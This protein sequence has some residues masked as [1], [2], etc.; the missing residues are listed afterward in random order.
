MGVGFNSSGQLGVVGTASSSV[1][2]PIPGLTAI[3][4]VVAGR[5]YSLALKPDGTVWAWGSNSSGIFGAATPDSSTSPVELPGLSGIT[6]ITAGA[7][8]ALALSADGHV[9]AWGDNTYGQLGNGTTS[10]NSTLTPTEVRLESVTS[11]ATGA[12]HNLAIGSDGSVWASGNDSNGQL[13]DGLTGRVDPT[14]AKVATIEHT[15]EIAAGSD[16]SLV[17]TADGTLYAFGAD[18]NGQLGDGGNSDQSSPEIVSGITDA[19][20]SIAAGASHSVVLTVGSIDSFGLNTSGQLGDD[21]TADSSVPVPVVS[22]PNNW[23]RPS[24]ATPLVVTAG[25]DST[26]ALY[27]DGSITSFGSNANGQLGDANH[28]DMNF[29]AVVPWRATPER[30]RS[31]PITRLRS[32]RTARYGLLAGMHSANWVTV[33]QWIRQCPSKS[34]AFLESLQLRP[35]TDTHLR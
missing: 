14:A 13:G 17:L 5:G 12:T 22:A 33:R 26:A 32:N 18:G 1:P 25:G 6:A 11:I 16:H 28:V 29:P 30:F 9:Y 2:V 35:V 15:V 23:N 27:S 24:Q 10:P 31:V 21:S 19:I 8:D 3:S 20:T 34:Q 7:G 4:S